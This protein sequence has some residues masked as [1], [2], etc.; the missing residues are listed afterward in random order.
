MFI[1]IHIPKTAGTAL[2]KV[3][4][5]TS[6]RRIMYDYGTEWDLAGA[7]TCPQGIH[8]SRNFIKSHFSYLHGHFHYYKYANT[9][10]DSPV[11]TTVRHPV[12]RV[13]S[14]YLHILRAGDRSI[15]Q[16]ALVMD[17]E[18][19]IVDLAKFK[20]IG[21][22]QHYYLEG[23]EVEDYDFIF[24]QE[25]MDVSLDKFCRKFNAVEVRRYLD[26]T[27]G[28]PKVNESSGSKE[29]AINVNISEAEKRQI[30]NICEF[31]VDIY[32]RTCERLKK[33]A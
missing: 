24:V 26:W 2:A 27:G 15:K 21:N 30:Y 12:D 28:L 7:R 29:V 17:R 6:R 32:R 20:Y 23:R 14:Q 8:D 31:D 11:I 4:D 16:H 1:S 5:D 9:F 13:I 10:P 19:G 22:A 18:I 33:L 3:F 25:S